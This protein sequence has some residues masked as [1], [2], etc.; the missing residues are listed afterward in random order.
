MRAGGVPCESI[1]A[2]AVVPPAALLEPSVFT[3]VCPAAP[4]RNAG[5]ASQPP[6][7]LSRFFSTRW[8]QEEPRGQTTSSMA[9]IFRQFL[10]RGKRVRRR[11][12]KART[13]KVGPEPTP[14][15]FAVWPAGPSRPV[16]R[17]L[18]APAARRR[19]RGSHSSRP[20]VARRLKRPNPGTSGGP[21][22]PLFGLAPG[23]VYRAPA[24]TGGPGELLPHRFTLTC[25]ARAQAV[26]FL[27]H[28]P[29][30][31]AGRR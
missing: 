10:L 21:P 4:K 17:I 3:G 25:A 9:L 12:S 2:R 29:R 28:F 31:T 27:L 1:A 24:V 11:P 7:S 18:S 20:P 23:G 14:G 26:C 30:L 19:M 16:S 22:V 5:G 13:R 15:F 8:R 6:A